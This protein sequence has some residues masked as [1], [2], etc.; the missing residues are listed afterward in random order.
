MFG[1][2]GLIEMQNGDVR[3]HANRNAAAA[4]GDV[5]CDGHRLA[6]RLFK[7]TFRIEDQEVH[8]EACQV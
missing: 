8:S 6:E 5:W 3:P 4:A 7:D 2:C 1:F